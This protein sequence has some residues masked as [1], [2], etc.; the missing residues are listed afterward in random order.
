MSSRSSLI[1]LL[2]L[3][4]LWLAASYGVR[5]ALMEDGQ[6]VGLCV[7]EAQRWECQVRAGLG[8]LIHFRIIAWIGLAAS[9][10]A[11][12]IPGRAGWGLALL[13]LLFALPALVL[14]TA[15]LAVFACVIAG[16]RL[17]RRQSEPVPVSA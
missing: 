12:L 11:F 5:F 15:S 14:Y 13:A 6:W 7:D 1:L 16:L 10:A 17:V 8:L 9:V 4:P 3:L 2:I